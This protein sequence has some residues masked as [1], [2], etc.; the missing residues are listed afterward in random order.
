MDAGLKLNLAKRPFF[1]GKL[2]YFGHEISGYGVRPGDNK[3]QVVSNF[4]PTENV[5]GA[6]Q[7]VGLAVTLGSLCRFFC[8]CPIADRSDGDGDFRRSR[9]LRF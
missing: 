9:C 2:E 5:H 6:R 1:K 4:P 3:M 7:F 8:H